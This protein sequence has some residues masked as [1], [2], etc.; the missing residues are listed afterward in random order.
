[1]TSPGLAADGGGPDV[2]RPFHGMLVAPD[3]ADRVVSPMLDAVSPQEHA[4]LLAARD[5]SWLH[6][7][8]SADPRVR[9]DRP[10]GASALRALLDAGAFEPAAPGGY[11][12]RMADPRGSHVGVVADVEA[13]AFVSGHVRG[14]EAV[15]PE[16]VA[17]VL[18]HFTQVPA[19]SELVTL[20]RQADPV[21][22]EIVARTCSTPP[23]LDFG[24]P[25]L[26]RQTVWRIADAELPRL[27]GRL[28]APPLYVADGHHRVAAALQSWEQAGRPD[29]AGILCVLY[30]PDGLR[31]EAFHRR[32]RGPVDPEQLVSALRTQLP[33]DETTGPEPSVGRLAVYVAGRW[34]A[35]STDQG[36]RHPGGVA[37]LDVA[38]L[39]SG[40]LEPLLGVERVA[41][42]RLE[43]TPA[44]EP[45]DRLVARC[46][47]DGGVL[48]VLEA[49]TVAQLAD[50]ADRGEVMMAKST[51]FEPKPQAGIFLH[52]DAT[53]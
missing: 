45:I 39:H 13:A 9:A 17:A 16:R 7:T 44:T 30:A 19:R 37:A 8:A 12:Y 24:S 52:L 4:A 14:H 35:V 34:L 46:D 29:A 47:G 1:M 18:R 22:D 11:V 50:V 36:T 51:F 41:D 26:L 5:H 3:W 10:T 15:Q 38:R 25:N 6:V 49:P 31:L 20:L 28:G 42:P 48:F 32:V 33:V 53:A 43:V 2:V 27:I 23:L 21:V 40:I